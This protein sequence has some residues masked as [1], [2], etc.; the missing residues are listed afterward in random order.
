MGKRYIEH[1]D[2]CGCERC[3]AEGDREHPGRVFDC[4]EDPNVLDCGC[5]GWRGCDCNNYDDYDD[6][7]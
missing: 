4:V 2:I 1:S 5:E 3:A 7:D 6:E